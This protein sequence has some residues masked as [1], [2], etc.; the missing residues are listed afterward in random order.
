MHAFFRVCWRFSL[1]WL[2]ARAQMRAGSRR[3]ECSLA[4][5]RVGSEREAVQ[6]RLGAGRDELREEWASE[7]LS[8]KEKFF[9]FFFFSS[10][11]SFLLFS[12][13]RNGR[14]ENKT[15]SVSLFSSRCSLE[16]Q[17]NEKRL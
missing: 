15:L 17:A 14:R 5:G 13:T 16:E 6:E 8:A 4:G 7:S 2:G 11:S 10:L 1:G 9:S 3:E 12:Y